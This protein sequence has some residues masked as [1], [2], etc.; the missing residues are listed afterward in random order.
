MEQTTKSISQ[1]G[2]TAKRSD[3][4]NRP[5]S[6]ARPVLHLPLPLARHPRGRATNDHLS[7]RSWPT[8]HRS[9]TF[10]TDGCEAPR[11]S[12]GASE[13]RAGHLKWTPQGDLP[14]FCLED[15]HGFDI[16]GVDESAE[17]VVDACL[18]NFFFPRFFVLIIIEQISVALDT[19]L[20]T[21]SRSGCA[22]L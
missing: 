9:W 2:F 7:R 4:R 8:I 3:H 14:R 17:K 5:S 19:T 22:F 18:C 15:L 21:F 12:V 13:R 1:K 20:G 6:L 16:Y 10:A 11:P